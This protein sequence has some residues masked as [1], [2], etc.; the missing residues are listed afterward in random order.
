MQTPTPPASSTSSTPAAAADITADK[1]SG[2]VL[3]KIRAISLTAVGVASLFS[4]FF[5]IDYFPLFDLQAASSYLFSVVW[6]LAVLLILLALILIVPNIVIGMAL[7]PSKSIRSERRLTATIIVWMGFGM[8]SL[9]G[10]SAGI[11]LV[12][13]LTW[14]PILGLL[15]GLAVNTLL[16]AVRTFYC[17][18]KIKKKHSSSV[19]RLWNIKKLRSLLAS[20]LGIAALSGA[21]QLMPLWALLL[22]FSRA[23]E[24]A[25]DSYMDFFA[26]L[27]QSAM[28]TAF[29]GGAV[30][31]VAFIPR[32]RKFWWVALFLIL[33]LPLFLSI[34]VRATGMLPMTM[35]QLTKIGNFRAEKLVLSPKACGSIAPIFGIDCDEK[36][37]PPIQLCNVHIMSRVGPE[38]YLRIADRKAGTDGKYPIH[39][40]FLPTSDI[41]SMEVNFEI[42]NRRLNLIDDD[43]AG[44]SSVCDATLTTLHGDSA[45]DFNDFTLTDSGKTQLLTFVQEIKSG[46]LGIQEVRVTGHADQIGQTKRN[47]WLSERRAQEVK[48]FMDK[49][50]INLV[51]EIKISATSEGSTHPVMKDCGVLTAL[52]E[53]IKCEA[54]NRRVELEIIKKAEA[55]P[56]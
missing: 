1:N 32:R 46:V 2:G 27:T 38:T 41:T 36:T 14:K 25:Q 56:K 12:T 48:L 24:M 50:L 23:S 49:R 54:P 42:K 40:I 31:Y 26:I 9:I 6:V 16:C 39:R 8:L 29:V 43:L 33:V 55:K 37:S 45:F 35:A 30:L 3:S 5:Y 18:K 17:V 4:Y 19:A 11:L 51:P 44:R 7:E 22:V 20:Q 13:W 52:K 34:V 10:W 15:I 53:R 28:F 21:L 47:I